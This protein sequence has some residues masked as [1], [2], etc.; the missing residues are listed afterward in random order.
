MNMGV[1]M[2]GHMGGGMG[3][4]MRGSV[5]RGMRTSTLPQMGRAHV[6]GGQH[7]EPD[8]PKKSSDQ[9]HNNNNSSLA[10]S[11]N[12]SDSSMFSNVSNASTMKNELTRV[13]ILCL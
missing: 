1:R 12:N 7:G 6:Y 5:G 4:N 11:K 8:L 10:N 9:E 13:K 3:L 2:G